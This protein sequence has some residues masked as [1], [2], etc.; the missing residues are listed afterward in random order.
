MSATIKPEPV[1]MVRQD[2]TV[3]EFRHA[4]S[5]I[6]D[7]LEKHD[8]AINRNA[9]DTREHILRCEGANVQAARDIGEIRNEMKSLRDLVMLIAKIGVPL[10][11]IILAVQILGVE[12]AWNVTDS[13]K[14]LRHAMPLDPL[15]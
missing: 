10:L 7:R 11:A 13:I 12:R 1:G 8:E 9:S 4:M 6:V 3:S 5:R 2:D 14:S 15:K